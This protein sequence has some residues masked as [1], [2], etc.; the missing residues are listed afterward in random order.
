MKI[1]CSDKKSSI[2]QSKTLIINQ[3][4]RVL[5]FLLIVIFFNSRKS[6][7]AF[8]SPVES[9]FWENRTKLFEARKI[10]S[11]Y[12]E[13]DFDEEDY[14]NSYDTW[15][16]HSTGYSG[17]SSYISQLREMTDNLNKN[18]SSSMTDEERDEISSFLDIV[19][20]YEDIKNDLQNKMDSI[21]SKSNFMN[22]HPLL[23]E[24]GFNDFAKNKTSKEPTFPIHND[25]NI[26]QW[27]PY[28]L[29]GSNLTQWIPYVIPGAKKAWNES[30][31]FENTDP[32]YSSTNK[33][34][35]YY[36]IK[37]KEYLLSFTNN[38]TDQSGFLNSR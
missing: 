30:S 24:S 11:Q 33:S 7:T 14:V 8:G 9:N 27:V 1:K 12:D 23:P 36:S 26:T 22:N 4:G 2:Q 6:F 35:K 28:M 3:M 19:N 10:F 18:E 31:F 13:A 32:M 38:V 20:E 34:S 25:V 29:P 37:F 15:I 17:N 16:K 5:M 21:K